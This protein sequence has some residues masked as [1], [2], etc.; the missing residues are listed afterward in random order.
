MKTQDLPLSWYDVPAE[1]KQLLVAAADSWEDTERSQVYIEQAISD[2]EV[3][4]DV[5]VAAYRYFFYKHNDP[6][7]LQIA[8][9]VMDRIQQSE[10]LPQDW[11]NLQPI[12]VDR[13]EEDDIRLYMNAYAAKGLVL[14][15]LGAIEEA[16]VITER[17]SAIDL[18]RESCAATVLDVLTH[19][20]DEDEDEDES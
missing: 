13:H 2:P 12:L 20:G 7:A 14:A 10:S 5:L 17:V 18:R 11:E 19:A 9:R 1:V 4:L 3:P 15:R 16:K 6:F 8:N